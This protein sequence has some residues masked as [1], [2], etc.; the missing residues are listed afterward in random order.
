MPIWFVWKYCET[1][2]LVRLWNLGFFQIRYHRKSSLQMLLVIVK[3]IET[4]RWLNIE[5]NERNCSLCN[6]NKF[7]DEYHYLL[8]CPFFSNDRRINLGNYFTTR[9][10]IL[11]FK[12]LLQ[13]INVQKLRKLCNF[14]RIINSKFVLLQSVC[15]YMHILLSLYFKTSA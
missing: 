6:L 1:N 10:N 2:T 3:P 13:Y 9:C 4:G 7:G 15:Y 12:T 14:I 11:K 5:R 8:E